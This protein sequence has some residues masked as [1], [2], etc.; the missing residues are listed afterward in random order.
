MQ[1]PGQDSRYWVGE[2]VFETNCPK[3]GHSVEFF[4]DDSQQK[5]RKCGHRILNPKIDF[6][7]A[8]YCPYADQCLG[9][10]PPELLARRDDLFKDKLAIA[11]RKYFGQ[12]HRRIKHAE[13]VASY[14]EEIGKME[15][16]NM[17][18]IMAA[19]YLHDIGIREAERKFNSSAP[20]YQHTEGPP[21]AREILTGLKAEEELIEEVCD[22]IG[23]HHLPREDE[24]IN[25]KVLYDA[26][27]IVNL[28]ERYR[29]KP[30]TGEKLETV[31]N[32]SFLTDSGRRVA[33][34]A[35]L[36]LAR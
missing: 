17:A 12:D 2:D 15:K 22:I 35:L 18:V 11:M 32:T 3:C 23:H 34:K 31:L 5:C 16:G 14:A 7:C 6:G 21:V 29:E 33:K 1:C 9:S 13:S 8:S 4:K 30:P 10:M 19:A 25:F 27:L 20:R 24:T 36:K 26:D 28:D